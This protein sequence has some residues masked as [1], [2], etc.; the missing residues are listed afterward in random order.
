MFKLKHEPSARRSQFFMNL[1]ICG[2]RRIHVILASDVLSID[3]R[4]LPYALPAAL[5]SFADGNLTKAEYCSAKA[6]YSPIK[7]VIGMDSYE[8]GT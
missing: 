5:L 6:G 7:F 3:C 2:F 8:K 1:I 4:R